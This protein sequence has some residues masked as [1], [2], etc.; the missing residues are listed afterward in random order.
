MAILIVPSMA[1]P[2][3]QSAVD[4]AMPGDIV[5]ILMGTYNENVVVEGK[6]DI[7]IRGKVRENVTITP[8][9]GQTG[10]GIMVL[11]DSFKVTI[12]NLTV[13]GSSGFST[14]ILLSGSECRLLDL[15]IINNTSFGIQLKGDNNLLRDIRVL[16]NQISGL[17]IDGRFNTIE[18]NTFYNN[19]ANGINNMETPVNDNLIINNT[20][21][22]SQAGILWSTKE[23]VN[24]VFSNNIIANNDVGFVVQNVKNL[25]ISN[26][27]RDN[28]EDGLDIASNENKV[29]NNVISANQNGV[30]IVGNRNKVI[31]NV[32]VCN[33]IENIIDTGK[34]NITEDNKLKR[35]EC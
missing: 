10:R 3:I 9:I 33:K 26:I 35:C 8:A 2:T 22:N 4:A 16:S 6:N 28:R 27:I 13:N 12:Q 23:S 20:I 15:Y 11:P 30:V 29:I 24:N 18:N 7:T 32:I 34:D 14:G 1:Y 31:C 21:A 17:V 19:L 25:I 5:E